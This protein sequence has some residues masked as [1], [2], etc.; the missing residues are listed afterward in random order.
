MI[1]G[2][3]LREMTT[4]A[5][6]E[7]FGDWRSNHI[8]RT[9]VQD[10]MFIRRH[11]A[12]LRLF[13]VPTDSAKCQLI[14]IAY[15]FGIACA[16]ISAIMGISRYEIHRVLHFDDRQRETLAMIRS[17]KATARAALAYWEGRERAALEMQ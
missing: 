10:R 6:P 4:P 11:A 13:G 15:G 5:D 7:S 12:A 16:A 8:V 17:R 2:D 1:N 14:H 9:K 3:Y